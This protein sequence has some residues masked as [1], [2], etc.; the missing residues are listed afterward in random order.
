MSRSNPGSVTTIV[1]A[2][3]IDFSSFGRMEETFIF[4][5]TAE[6][7]PLFQYGYLGRRA[8]QLALRRIRYPIPLLML[9]KYSRSALG[10]VSGQLEHHLD[11]YTKGED[12]ATLVIPTPALLA[13]TAQIL[14]AIATVSQ[15]AV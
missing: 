6:T 8:W 12:E 10:R 9:V 5:S 1:M 2:C 4:T 15:G 7:I 14:Y 3:Y 13:A 11:D